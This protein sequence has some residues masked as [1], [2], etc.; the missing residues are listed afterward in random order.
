MGV[1]SNVGTATPSLTEEV[2]VVTANEG[3]F[4]VLSV[5]FEGGRYGG[6]GELEL[7]LYA[8][9]GTGAGI[10][11]RVAQARVMGTADATI[12]EWKDV[13]TGQPTSLVQ[14]AGAAYRV[15]VLDLS[16]RLPAPGQ[17]DREDVTIGISGTTS[18]ALVGSQATVA[19]LAPG[20]TDTLPDLG[21][22]HTYM[23]VAVDQTNLPPVTITVTAEVKMG[24]ITEMT[25]IVKEVLM[26]GADTDI[27]AVF[28]KLVLPV[29][30][31]Y[32]VSLTNESDATITV[33]YGAG[34][35]D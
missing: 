8:N 16:T 15:T 4:L 30:D 12:V 22:Y 13:V 7:A 20:A 32:S 11:V 6:G 17:P 9:I 18:A 31:D 23:D 21:G 5:Y 3:H 34:T 19:T 25:A 29:A 2:V 10:W 33:A 28:R 27:A 14:C 26:S 35:F 24:G 1:N